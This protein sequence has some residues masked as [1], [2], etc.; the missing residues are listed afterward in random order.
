MLLSGFANSACHGS[1]GLTVTVFQFCF[2]TK[3]IAVHYQSIERFQ[4]EMTE[5]SP[6]N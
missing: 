5:I 6:K 2:L 3:L 4:W 1:T